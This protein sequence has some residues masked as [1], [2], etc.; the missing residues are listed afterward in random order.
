MKK[1]DAENKALNGK[2]FNDEL[3]ELVASVTEPAKGLL[4]NTTN[5]TFNECT[6]SEA[7][8]EIAQ[9][10]MQSNPVEVE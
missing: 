1:L 9:E 10:T 8:L 2:P 3:R 4:S 6:H 7:P 5:N